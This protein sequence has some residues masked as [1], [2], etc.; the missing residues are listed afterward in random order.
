MLILARRAFTGLPVVVTCDDRLY[1]VARDL[2]NLRTLAV[3]RSA[4]DPTVRSSAVVTDQEARTLD[5]LH[6]VQI[7]PTIHLAQDDIA[8]GQR[9]GIYGLDRTELAGLDLP[10]HRVP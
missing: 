3:D 9:R 8:D 6:Q 4:C 1:H 10:L 5:R 7:L 2:L